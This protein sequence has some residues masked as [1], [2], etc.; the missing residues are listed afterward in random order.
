MAKKF[1]NYSQYMLPEKVEYFKD[2]V[3][4]Q[5]IVIPNNK[6]GIERILDIFIFVDIENIKFLKTKV[7]FSIEGQRLSGYKVAVDLKVS[8]EITYF[9]NKESQGINVINFEELISTFVVVPKNI[10]GEEVYSLI[11][12]GRLNVMPYIEA[13]ESRVLDSRRIHSCTLLCLDIKNK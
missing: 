8:N 7:G 3:I 4:N 9:S 13:V 10:N 5:V 2:E 11:K 12:S 6:P 1:R